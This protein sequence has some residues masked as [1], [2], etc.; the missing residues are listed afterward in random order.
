[1]PK[2][3]RGGREPAYEVNPSIFADGGGIVVIDGHIKV[4]PPWSPEAIL[5]ARAATSMS[6][7]SAAV[8][9]KALKADLQKLAKRLI[10][11]YAGRISEGLASYSEMVRPG[12]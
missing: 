8:R 7:A 11:E 2:K 12:E 1:M 3:P 6:A 10:D 5:L 4:I 9:D